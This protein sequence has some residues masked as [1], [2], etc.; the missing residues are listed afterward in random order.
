MTETV[1]DEIRSTGYQVTTQCFGLHNVVIVSI[2][3]D[4]IE[5]LP[6]DRIQLGYDNPRKYLPEL[7]V[8]HL[9]EQFSD[10]E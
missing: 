1:A 3:M 2:T 4:G 9:D 5:Q 7:I 6:L 8:R 10:S